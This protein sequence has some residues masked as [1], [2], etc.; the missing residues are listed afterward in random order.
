LAE[1]DGWA[2]NAPQ[3]REYM[4]AMSCSPSNAPHDEDWAEFL[5]NPDPI[6]ATGR[7][8]FMHLPHG[9][10]CQLCAAPFGGVGGTVMRMV[11]RSPS[12]ANPNYCTAC[13]RHLLKHRGGAEVEAAMLFA[14]IRGSTTL[15]EKMPAKRFHDLLDRF[16][17]V[18]SEAV[19]A[20]NGFVDKF[21]GDELV[22]IFP[23][24]LSGGRHT[25]RAIGA[26][27]MLLRRTGHEDPDG[28]WAPVGAGV[29]TGRAWFGVVGDGAYVELTAV[30]DEVNVAARL[31]SAA[32]AG[33]I[34]VS[35]AAAELA[36][37]DPGL[38]R[39]SLELKGKAEPIPV[40]SL[41]VRPLVAD[42][43]SSRR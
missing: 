18:A 24:M 14:D 8:L 6:S 33:E 12:P 21:V 10:R 40:V 30:G 43:R 20:N 31:A 27:R 3:V 7:R 11:G 1:L 23:P 28:P 15:A 39:R 19:F 41:Y 37:L 2:E 36:N 4:A 22:A 25:E 42:A 32:A 34:L 35:A 17:T 29:H 16:Y 38:E 9:P 5:T 26:A 13:A